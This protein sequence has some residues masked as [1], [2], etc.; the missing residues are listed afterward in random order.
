MKKILFKTGLICLLAPLF[1]VTGTQRACAQDV[2]ESS[3][4]FW[5]AVQ[6]N[7]IHLAKS[8]LEQGVDPNEPIYLTYTR[9]KDDLIDV[10]LTI[11]VKH[12][13][14][15]MIKLLLENGADVN[16]PANMMSSVPLMYANSLDAAKILVEDYQ[17]DLQAVDTFQANVLMYVSNPKVFRYLLDAGADA[18]MPNKWGDTP[19]TRLA[20][21]LTNLTGERFVNSLGCLRVLVQAKYHVNLKHQSRE[22]TACE[23]IKN[24]AAT[25]AKASAEERAKHKLFLNHRKEL[26][27]LLCK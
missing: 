17:A 20:T 16:R 5:H 23:I 10:P 14:V 3:Q 26:T 15:D 9:A 8:L 11:A 25:L 4:Q 1:F 7:Q 19:V 18:N 21:G 22:G 6:T 24:K 2:S 13:Y 27:R 12:N